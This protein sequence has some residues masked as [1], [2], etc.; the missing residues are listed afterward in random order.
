MK[1]VNGSLSP[2]YCKLGSLVIILMN[3]K[4]NWMPAKLATHFTS[5]DVY[6]WEFRWG[7]LIVEWVRATAKSNNR[8]LA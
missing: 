2:A 7:R 4:Y 5:N 6:V 1:H 8:K 3:K